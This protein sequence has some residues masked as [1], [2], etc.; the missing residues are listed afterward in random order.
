M[1]R[2]DIVFGPTDEGL[3]RDVGDLGA[4]VGE[5]LRE[6]RGDALFER[7][8]EAR[9]AAI[10]RRM[11]EGDADGELR[12]LTKGLAASDASDLV[13]AFST[14]FQAVNLAERVH[15]IRRRRDYQ[16]AR[17]GPQPGGVEAALIRLREDGVG[18]AEAAQLLA[19]VCFEP[20]FTAHPTE[21]VRRTLLEKQ[22]RIARALI[23]RLDPSLTPEEEA[24]TLARI[25]TEI[26]TAWQTDEHPSARL[27]VADEL[28]HVL[29]YVT[30][31]IYRV[32]PPFVEGL[33][34]AFR[35][36]FGEQLPGRVYP[37]RFSSWVGG[38]MDGNP[39]VDADTFR[40]AIAEHRRQ[41]LRL[42]R[43]EV[44]RLGRA[45]SQ[46]SRRIPASDEVAARLEEYARDFA[47]LDRTTP[48]RHRDMPYR[49]LLR[50]VE[51]RL[52]ARLR[53]ANGAY[54]NCAEFERDLG[55]IADSLCHHR[56]EHAGWF[57]L[58]RLRC[59]VAVFGFHLLSL[60]LREDAAEFHDG[61]PRVRAALRAVADARSMDPRAAGTCVLSMARSAA[62]VHAVLELARSEGVVERDG[63]VP[64][65]IAPLFETV[66]DLESAAGVLAELAKDTGYRAHL[67]SRG[68]RQMVML[69]YSDSNK[70]GGL[71]AARWALY[72]C[73]R[74]LV[75]TA[76][77][78]GIK[79]LLFH[80]RGGTT[81]RGGGKIGSAVQAAPAGAL[82]G[83]LRVTE[84]GEIINAKYGLR[85]IAARTLDQ[86][87]GAIIDGS[88]MSRERDAATEQWSEV[89]ET[90][91]SASRDAYRALVFDD[92]R[93]VPY[94][95][96]ATPIDVIERMMIG[97]RPSRRAADGDVRSLRAIPWVF[98]WTQNR[99]VLPGWFGLGTGLDA[100]EARFGAATL[101]QMCAEWPF[102]RS[103]LDDAAMVL[104]KSDISIAARYADL[105]EPAVRGVFG[106]IADE[107]ERTRV[108]VLRVQGDDELLASEPVLQRSIRLR[109][110]YVDP[111]SLLQIDLLDRWRATG[112]E[113][114]ALFEALLASVNGI[115]Q[116]LQ[117]TG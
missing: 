33:G 90:V 99:A 40:Q 23:D 76:E 74:E 11:G 115:A 55:A 103:L 3:R 110:P 72:R 60:D 19:G 15:R 13:R 12:A 77:A 68:S 24:T 46:S 2:R 83:H 21:A 94:F 73:Q 93:L 44:R 97:S 51:A 10:R 86:A 65:D 8:E 34:D 102:F 69:G 117:N 84:Q 38:D 112:R 28:E 82:D 49:R 95:L 70:D 87:I 104:A 80:G 62:D 22:Q 61:G 27:T 88:R 114:E 81:S 64:L 53:D 108:A 4:L 111:M 59:R 96:Q 50:F 32:V 75:A 9:A 31:V 98:A 30:D 39:N 42:Y 29:F 26:T 47:E 17:S 107:F 36:V 37:L 113:D 91:A 54:R 71:A 16:R 48:P 89:M 92:H 105:A 56:G 52:T 41:V 18:A 6:Q 63:S 106:T 116:G 35:R 79:L 45:L 20:V 43:A 57:A 7:V 85:G 5:V 78:E 109:N 1:D 100:A 25:R 58:E 67:G 14:Y 66:E 101:A